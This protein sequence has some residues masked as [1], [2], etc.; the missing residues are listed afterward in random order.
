MDRP[1]RRGLA[2]VYGVLA[3]VLLATAACT[4]APEEEILSSYFRALRMRDNTTL[5]NIA[6][7]TY[8]GGTVQSFEI[9]NVGQEQRRPLRVRDLAKAQQE[10]QA[11]QDEFS[12]KMKSYQ[13]ENVEAINRIIVAERENT[14]LK[15]DDVTVQGEWN[16]FREELAQHS[17]E[18]SEAR[19]E[20]SR[21]RS[22]AEMSVVTPQRQVDVTQYDG[23]LVT[24]EVTINAAVR[25]EGGEAS[26][27]QLVVTLQ[28]AELTGGPEGEINGRWIVTE[29]REA[30]GAPAT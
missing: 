7:A 1:T 17:K 24:K 29:V 18:V 5:S 30:G 23:E 19:Q 12:K 28:R 11:S 2:W 8:E 14:E 4:S 27:R 20:L 16:K 21:E 9:V 15:G 26:E 3:G 6:S 25:T 22:A 10:A 13:D